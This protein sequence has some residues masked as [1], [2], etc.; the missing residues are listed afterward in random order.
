MKIKSK[1]LMI[2][3]P[4]LIVPLA[5]MGFAAS[6]SARNGITQIAIDFLKF[7]ADSLE[8]YAVSQWSLL[9]ENNLTASKEFVDAAEEAVKSFA[10]SLIRS[11][12]ELI[13]AVDSE[14]VVQIASRS[15]ETGPDELPAL[16][17]L[18]RGQTPGWVTFSIENTVR[19]AHGFYFKPFDWYFLISESRSVFYG[20]VFQ[21]YYQSG[22][23][24]FIAAIVSII[25][26]GFFI[27]Y[28]TS[29]LSK[30][31]AVMREV[32]SENDLSK[33]VSLLY[34]DEIGELGHTFNL[35]SGELEKAYNQ[36]KSYAYKAVIAEKQEK[37]IRNIF[38]KYVPHDVI[39][40]FFND[41][42]TMLTG[43]SRVLAVLF[44]DIRGFTTISEDM[45]PEMVVESLNK[46]F[47]LMVDIVMD[48]GGIVDKYM[49]D[50]I[51]AF[52]GAPVQHE[53][54]SL[55]AVQTGLGM[56]DELKSFNQW[57]EQY[58]RPSFN[59]GIGVNYGVVTVGNI[60]SEKKMDYTVIGDMVN[61]ASR[62]ESLTKKYGRSFII[63]DSVYDKV[64]N[65][66]AC[67]QLDIV[68]VK[69]RRKGI[70]VYSVHRQLSSSE[71]EAL[72][73]YTEGLDLYYKKNFRQAMNLFRKGQNL[74]PQDSMFALYINRC[75]EL[76]ESPPPEDW[77]GVT[78][79]EYK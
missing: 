15:M 6:L 51:M 25:L 31:V 8:N 13:F 38:Q 21:I 24:L 56:L 12:T 22:M 66:F 53:N 41:P 11:E 73:I 43:S 44:S 46:Y 58:N 59:I 34:K 9:E 57:Q 7:K 20:S 18:H 28:L 77:T 14:G 19:V 36:V 69:G 3:L 37:K 10:L 32:I 64:K 17:E 48:H 23:I 35:M 61:T 47:G 49:G 78:V 72:Q 71:K 75:R 29:P 68:A 67:Q 62:L 70:P 45:P 65:H 63:S 74:F 76:I 50:A 5:L 39:E 1:I 27:S 30:I 16:I 4:V 60:G 2:V 54:D 42:E 79:M 33:R 26:L 55:L 40:Q 52:F